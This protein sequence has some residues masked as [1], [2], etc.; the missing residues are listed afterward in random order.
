VNSLLQGKYFSEIDLMDIAHQLGFHF[1]FSS[2][3]MLTS[4]ILILNILS[5]L[6]LSFIDSQERGQLIGNEGEEVS[7]NVA[8][9]GNYRYF[10]SHFNLSV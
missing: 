7:G 9:D 8:D 3:E 2:N 5:F 10:F 6:F 4:S 1:I